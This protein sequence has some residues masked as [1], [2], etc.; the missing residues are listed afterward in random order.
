[1]SIYALPDDDIWFPTAEMYDNQNDI[2]AVGGDLQLDRIVTA[3]SMGIFPWYNDPEERLWWCPRER[4]V[5]FYDA[6]KVSHSMRNVM[7]KH[8]YRITMDTDFTGVL[9]GCRG[10]DRAGETWLIDEMY[11]AYHSL[12]EIGF[13]HSVEVWEGDELVGGLYGVSL[14]RMFYGESM[15]S[16]RSNTSKLAFIHLAKYLSSKGWKMLDCQVVTDHLLSLGC[17]SI[18]RSEFLQTLKQELQYESM[19]GKWT[20]DFAA[21]RDRNH[22]SLNEINKF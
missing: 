8:P 21:S 22:R 20:E 19:I 10:G 17:S 7:N 6:L 11:N 14:G 16:R 3:Y 13:G 4:C 1:M 5:L 12:H 15:F 18:P 2:V 9:D